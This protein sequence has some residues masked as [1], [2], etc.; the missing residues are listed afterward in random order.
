MALNWPYEN[1]GE[2]LYVDGEARLIRE[3]ESFADLLRGQY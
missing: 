2:Y 3:R 1:R